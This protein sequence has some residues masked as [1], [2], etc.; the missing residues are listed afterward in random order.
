VI[1]TVLPRV[2]VKE[3]TSTLRKFIEYFQYN[4]LGRRMANGKK[5]GVVLIRRA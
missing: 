5:K 3:H 2:E 1:R 4:E